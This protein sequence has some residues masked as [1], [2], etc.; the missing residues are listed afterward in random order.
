MVDDAYFHPPNDP[1]WV[2]RPMINLI[3]RAEGTDPVAGNRPDARGY[4]ETLAFGALTGG[5]VDLV[6]MTLDEVAALQRRMLDHPDN[7]WNSSAVGRLQIVRKTLGRV[8]S[9]LKLSGKALF[10]PAM[11]DMLTCYLLGA[12]GIDRWLDGRMSQDA[13]INALAREWASFPTMAGVSHYSRGRVPQRARVSVD[14]VRQALAEVRRRHYR[15]VARPAPAPHPAPSQ[16]PVAGPNPDLP[17]ADLPDPPRPL[18]DGA[19][20]DGLSPAMVARLAA[21]PVSELDRAAQLIALA[22]AVQS[23][24]MVDDPDKP[25]RPSPATPSAS[26]TLEKERSPMTGSK[27]LFQSKTIWG[28]AVAALSMWS[29]AIGSILTLFG[30]NAGAD[31]DPAQLEHLVAALEQLGAALG[32]VFAAWGRLSARDKVTVTGK[33]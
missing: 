5:P 23:G 22:R 14:D 24:W 3:G 6:S 21:R 30:V 25:G 10:D 17:N 18:P 4:N 1:H 15:Q 31:I 27:S 12:R 28:L 20:F 26:L 9:R 19:L 8:R 13:L 33:S 7:E 16:P 29:P 32:M 2:Y 11:Q